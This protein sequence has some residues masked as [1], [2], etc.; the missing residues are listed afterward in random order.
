MFATLFVIL[1]L[2]YFGRTKT[3]AS[4]VIVL[5]VGSII[6][7]QKILG[8]KI[9]FIDDLIEKLERRETRFIGYGSAWLVIGFIFTI[10]FFTD[11]DKI[12]AILWIL[13]IGDG[14]S[15]LFGIN[16]KHKLFYNKNKTVEGTLA[17]FI[18][19]LVGYIFI[20]PQII[21]LSFGCSFIESIPFSK[22]GLDDNIT[23]PIVGTIILKLI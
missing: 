23:I 12:L 3:L 10:V 4:M 11:I 5:I 13:G 6:I 14:F 8:K 2:I 20:G 22:I 1:F 15:T 21:I 19:G 7:N 17:L 16:G 9:K 18:S